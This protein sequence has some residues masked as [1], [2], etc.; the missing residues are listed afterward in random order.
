MGLWNLATR[1]IDKRIDDAFGTAN[2]KVYT[3]SD[4]LVADLRSMTWEN[5]NLLL[6]SSGNFHG[7]DLNAFAQELIH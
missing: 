3:D 6:M 2:V 7:L 4:V 1:A 5:T